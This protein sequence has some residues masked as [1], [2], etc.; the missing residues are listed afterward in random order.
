MKSREIPRNPGP[1][2]PDPDDEQRRGPSTVQSPAAA[3]S[4]SFPPTFTRAEPSLAD[5]RCLQH[6]Y[7]PSTATN[8]ASPAPSC[9]TGKQS[10]CR[11]S[12]DTL[13]CCV[14]NWLRSLTRLSDVC[15]DDYATPARD[16][17]RLMSP[18]RCASM[19][20]W[21]PF[22]AANHDSPYLSIWHLNLP[23]HIA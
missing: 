16:N 3:S 6:V 11:Q 19:S 9:V 20:I 22:F 5:V 8:T 15:E 14:R 10:H 21:P 4:G 1:G 18:L 13:G 23:A 2:L 17:H 7:A 12:S